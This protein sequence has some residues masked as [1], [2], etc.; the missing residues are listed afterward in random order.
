MRWL[1]GLEQ[2]SLALA[3]SKRS[4]K[5]NDPKQTFDFGGKKLSMQDLSPI[6]QKWMNEVYSQLLLR[7]QLS[8]KLTSIVEPPKP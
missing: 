1:P 2:V 8:L 4:S 5:G 6:D 7:E 3:K